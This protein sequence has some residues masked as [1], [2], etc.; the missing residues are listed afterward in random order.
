MSTDLRSSITPS[1]ASDDYSQLNF[2][3]KALIS[4]IN[5]SIPCVVKS[6]TN[7][8][9]VSPIGYVDI[10]T[11]ATDA[12]GISRDIKLSLQQNMLINGSATGMN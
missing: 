7:N 6:V 12:A 11:Q 2:V 8:G 5:T 1:A 9:S 10:Q 4:D 3:I